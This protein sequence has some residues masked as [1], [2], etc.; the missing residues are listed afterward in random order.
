MNPAVVGILPTQLAV[1]VMWPTRTTVSWVIAAVVLRWAAGQSQSRPNIVFILADDLGWNDVGFH[2]ST[3]IRT[4]NIDDLA[5]S[6]IMLN[7]Y[8]VN[9]ICTPSRS[10]LLTGKYPIHTGMEHS[11]ILE[12]EPWGLGLD[13]ILL[14][15]YLAPLGY[16][17]HIVGKW[18]LGFFQKE[19]TPTYRG[20]QTH[21]GYWSGK[22]DYWSH[23]SEKYISNNFFMTGLDMRLNMEP[24]H[25]TTGRYT[26]DLLTEAATL[27]IHHHK[28]DESPLF[29]YLSHLAVHSANKEQPLQAPKELGK[30][31]ASQGTTYDGWWDGWYGPAEQGTSR[32]TSA[33]ENEILINNVW[34]SKSKTNEVRDA[35]ADGLP[36]ITS[37]VEEALQGAGLWSYSY[38]DSIPFKIDCGQKVLPRMGTPCNPLHGRPCLFHVK[39]DPCEYH[40][41]ADFYPD[42]LD[43]L[44]K[45]MMTIAATAVPARNQPHDPEAN[46][47][48][49]CYLWSTWQSQ[50]VAFS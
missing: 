2:G 25:N 5:Y 33:V 48:K 39:E 20:F 23:F 17:R 24:A 1:I 11:V 27:I 21:F 3:A 10:S 46:P 44:W 36:R 43:S 47:A 12:T 29:L 38:S 9:P 8:Y 15:E 40:N 19:Y 16:T 32:D 28:V 41:L 14:P 7:N 30:I 22:H 4:P 50:E 18:H 34:I 45:R 35:A 31:Y 49:H 26:T 6:G 37:Q 13:E 42:I